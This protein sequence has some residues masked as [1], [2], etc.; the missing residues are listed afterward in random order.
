MK[1]QLKYFVILF[2]SFSI[3]STAQIKIGNTMPLITLKNNTNNEVDIT[4]FKGK[5]VL[6]DFWASWCAPCR[7]ENPN[8]VKQFERFKGKNFS[9]LGISLDDDRASWLQAIKDDQLNWSHLSELK[10]WDGKV[11]ILYKIEGIPA[12][13]LLDPKGKIIAKNLRGAELELFLE[14]TL[15]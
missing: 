3:T 10:K 11:S 7:E 15:K 5:Y 4:S 12:S 1:N 13:F 2:I 6:V 9:V 14:K 8:I